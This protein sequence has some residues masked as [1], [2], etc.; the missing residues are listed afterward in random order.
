[1]TNPFTLTEDQQRYCLLKSKSV[2]L[3]FG[4]AIVGM[5]AF[6]NFAENDIHSISRKICRTDAS[7]IKRHNFKFY[8]SCYALFEHES[9]DAQIIPSD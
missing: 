8:V 9:T 1:M 4:N 7:L 3:S 6:G 2:D 5:T